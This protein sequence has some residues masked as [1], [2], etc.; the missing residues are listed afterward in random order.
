M[1]AQSLNVRIFLRNY[2][3]E[4]DSKRKEE[5]EEGIQIGVQ[6]FSLKRQIFSKFMRIL[7]LASALKI[8][9]RICQGFRQIHFFN[10]D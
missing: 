8:Y 1:R 2:H 3:Q 4:R 9:I 7:I 10:C 6:G 5:K